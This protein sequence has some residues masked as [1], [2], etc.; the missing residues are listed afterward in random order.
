MQK[1]LNEQVVN[2]YEQSEYDKGQGA[3]GTR[4]ILMLPEREACLMAMSYSY[5]LQAHVY[6]EWQKLVQAK[7]K[8]T[9]SILL[10]KLRDR[11]Q[12]LT[13]TLYKGSLMNVT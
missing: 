7:P 10:V 12:Y 3:K 2:F 9:K 5:E 6:D 13:E 1:V 4:T 11:I 8:L